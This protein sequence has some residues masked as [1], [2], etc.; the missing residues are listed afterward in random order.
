MINFF[1]SCTYEYSSDRHR[2]LNLFLFVQLTISIL[3][4]HKYHEIAMVWTIYH[5]FQ[6]FQT[7]QHSMVG[8]SYGNRY[9]NEFW[10]FKRSTHSL[11]LSQLG[12][13]GHFRFFCML[14]SLKLKLN[15]LNECVMACWTFLGRSREIVML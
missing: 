12:W 6:I 15:R 10:A 14:E 8:F 11:L 2:Q 9:P 13:A 4:N 1:L 5:I 3:L 7:V